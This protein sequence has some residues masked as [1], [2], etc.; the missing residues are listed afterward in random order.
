A[1]STS[2][3][4]T[5]FVTGTCTTL[6]MKTGTRFVTIAVT[7]FVATGSRVATPDTAPDIA[8][9]TYTT[10]VRSVTTGTVLV[11]TTVFVNTCTVGAFVHTISLSYALS[12]VAQPDNPQS[13][14]TAAHATA[15]RPVFLFSIVPFIL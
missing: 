2:G 13:T 9:V 4:A 1:V 14:A 11:T 8:F 7:K 15:I 10:F 12:I 5:R 3:L 6:V